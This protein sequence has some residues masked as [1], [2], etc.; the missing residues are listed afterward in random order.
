MEL[1]SYQEKFLT[2]LSN[3]GK[4]EK[5]SDLPM[6]QNG[7]VV[8]VRGGR[9][10]NPIRD[11]CFDTQQ[12]WNTCLTAR[13]RLQP[14][15]IFGTLFAAF[16]ADL[17]RIQRGET[18]FHGDLRPD[19]SDSVW[20]VLLE[21]PLGSLVDSWSEE[22][23]GVFDQSRLEEFLKYLYD[24]KILSQEMRLVLFGEVSERSENRSEWDHAMNILLHQLPERFGLVFS[25]APEDF[26]LP[27]DVPH[28]LEISLPE[29]VIGKDITPSE[30]ITKYIPS[31]FHSDRPAQEDRLDVNTYAEALAR[32][33][34]HAQTKPPLTLGIHGPW[35]KGKSSFMKLVDIALVKWA[36]VNRVSKTQELAD[37][38]AGIQQKEDDVESATGEEKERLQSELDSKIEEH[39]QLWKK[40]QRAA[41]KEV[42]T[43]WFNAWQFEDAK[44]IWA[45]LASRIL[46]RLERVLPLWSRF[47]MHVWYAWKKR[48]FELLFKLLLP[49]FIAF[50][51]G[52]Y[53]IF[54]GAEQVTS[55]IKNW[56]DIKKLLDVLLPVV[57]STL[58][59]FWFVVW[60]IFKV[61]Q[62]VSERVLGYTQLPKYREQMGYQH[63]VMNDL[64]FVYKHLRRRWSN[65]KVVVFIDD[66]DRCSEEKIMEVLQ[67]I[68]LILG[69]S[70]FFVFMG[71]DTEMIYRAIRVY[72]RK[73]QKDEPLPKDF[74]ENYLRKI[75][76]LSFHLPEMPMEKRFAFLSTLFSAAAR[77]ELEQQADESKEKAE[78]EVPYME[79]VAD[80]SFRFDFNLL[81]K[82]IPSQL[83]EVEDTADE[84]LAFRDYQTFLEDNPREIKRIVNVHRLVKI[85]L[86]QPDTQWPAERQ[87]KLVKWLI[88][89]ANWPD[90]IGKLLAEVKEG[91]PRQNCLEDFIETLDIPGDDAQAFDRLREFAAQEK[92]VLSSE[93]IDD[94][95]IFGAHISQMVR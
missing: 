24:E 73:N 4:E 85:L 30:R 53:V 77:C 57:G 48:R 7:F 10:L 47:W 88:F 89:C 6:R 23:Q 69:N 54:R 68:N 79:P 52:I 21:G 19:V 72:Y 51:L 84:L 65:C 34:L 62:P 81:E 86:Q 43:V 82:P 50:P 9:D 40:M 87:R 49:V 8:L 2:I 60:R 31:P 20:K 28:F 92:D 17:Q 59:L 67:A 83:E 80:G 39:K 58:F 3:R 15:A 12:S 75:V 44:Q 32:F 42:L 78:Q 16:L 94:G 55:F 64:C 33:I 1:E 71:M 91:P 14:G 22:K 18:D 25:G 11:L 61:I 29:D 76:Q 26:Y 41:K 63:R 70:E 56:Q 27:D 90:L 66:L 38:Q 95:F 37:L 35:G 93:D 36:S 45:G 46:E 74:P 13:Y 5:G